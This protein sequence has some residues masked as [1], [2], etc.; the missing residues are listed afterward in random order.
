MSEKTVTEAIASLKRERDAVILAHNYQRSEVQDIADFAGDSLELARKAREND[1]RVVVFCGVHFMAETA[2]LLSPEKIVLIP[3]ENAGC[4]MA[5][6]ADAP[7]VLAM[8][9][10][11]PG[12]VVICYVNSTAAVKAVSDA[13]CTSSNAAKIVARVPGDRE[14]IFVPDRFL[15]A[16]VMKITGREMHLWPGYCPVHNKLSVD[17]ISREKELHPGAVVMVHPEC[18]E[19]VCDAADQVLSTGGMCS[20]AAASDATEFIVGTEPGL[21]HRLRKENPSRSFIPVFDEAVCPDM[22]LCTLEKIRDAIDRLSPRIVVEESTAKRA[23]VSV[24]RMFE[25]GPITPVE[26]QHE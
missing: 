4:P 6:M 25:D 26:D 2:A 10:E 8:K 12:A 13:C 19:A 5:D 1:A 7:A 24:M 17:M 15:G 16:Q 22:K 20:F 14:I 3:D 21:L 18:V 9:K 11:P 23:A